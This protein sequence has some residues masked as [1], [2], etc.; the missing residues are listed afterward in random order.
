MRIAIVSNMFSERMGYLPNCLPKA[1]A[2]WGHDV[3]VVASNA[4]AYFDTPFYKETYEAHLG[5]PFV[6]T[7]VKLL[8]GFTLHRLPLLQWRRRLGIKGLYGVLKDLQPDVVQ[9]LDV[10]HL[11]AYQAALYQPLLGYRFFTANHIVASVFPAATEH[12]R[13]GAAERLRLFLGLVPLGRLV[14][15][16]TIKCY[17]ATP[18]ALDIAVRFLGVP[19]EKLVLT[20]LGT[21]TEIFHP[22]DTEVSQRE[23]SALRAKLGF[24]DEDIVC[25]YTGR[26]TDFKNPLCL[27][28]AIA[29]L[30]KMG[31][32][33]R[34]LFVGTG[35]QQ[36]GIEALPGNSVCPFVWHEELP[37]L[38]RAADIGVWPQQESMSML[39]AAAC[40]IPIVI[41]RRVQAVERVE[42]N[43]ET[44][45]EGDVSDLVRALLSLRDPSR[46]N[47]LGHAGAYKMAG[48]YS[49]KSIAQQRLRDYEH[50]LDVN[51]KV[52]RQ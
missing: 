27:A 45:I 35:P 41:S 17:A 52:V 22:A 11:T 48:A 25:I 12:H 16:R 44:Y 32:P 24:N 31:E 23:R 21:D 19:A 4:Q 30:V 13:P 20:S 40:G 33:F 15:S 39:D 9:A 5:P 29:L 3:H 7:G 51:A 18:D 14:S 28:Q 43:G 49:W 50:A 2:Y 34:G 37:Q 42:G 36:A 47:Q 46:R 8:D 38:Y 1:L 6:S 26:F 10:I